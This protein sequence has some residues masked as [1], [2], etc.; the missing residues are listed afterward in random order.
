MTKAPIAAPAAPA[1]P[2]ARPIGVL[3]TPD[4]RQANTHGD[5]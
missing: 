5:H 3:A 2:I 1:S 4:S